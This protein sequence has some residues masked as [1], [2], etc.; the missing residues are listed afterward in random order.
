M[1]NAMGKD[2][3]ERKPYNF[4]RDYYQRSNNVVLVIRG[5]EMFD[6]TSKKQQEVDFLIINYSRQY[7][8][9]VECKSQIETK[10]KKKAGTQLNKIRFLMHD[11][12]KSDLKGQWTYISALWCNE[13]QQL[14]RPQDILLNQKHRANPRWAE[15]QVK[16]LPTRIITN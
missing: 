7:I 11:W 16:S 9:N 2:F 10:T 6:I 3:N 5:L 13:A 1:K 4:F 14:T 15:H 8:M 12:F